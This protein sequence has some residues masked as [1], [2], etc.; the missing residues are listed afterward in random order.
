[1][2]VVAIREKNLL[3]LIKSHEKL[4]ESTLSGTK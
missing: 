1:M 4:D 2:E 3:N